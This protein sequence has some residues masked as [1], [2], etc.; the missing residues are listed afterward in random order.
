MN[1]TIILA[2]ASLVIETA[3]TAIQLVKKQKSKAEES[4]SAE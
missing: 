3:L 2:I 4:R 1:P